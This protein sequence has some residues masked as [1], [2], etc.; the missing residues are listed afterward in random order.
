MGQP[1]SSIPESHVNAAITHVMS[2]RGFFVIRKERFNPCELDVLLLDPLSLRLAVI[3]IKRRQWKA[4]LSQAVRAMLF[5][6]YVTAAM[7]ASME[8]CGPA[9]EFTSRGVGLA[10]YEG[11]TKELKLRV[12]SP[13]ALSQRINRSLK[14]QV[15]KRFYD[16]CGDLLYA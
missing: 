9:E 6:H 4:L 3:E 12:V 8:A 5:C 10:F 13:P 11:T 7:P 2:R 16:R 14:R 15:Y 1:E